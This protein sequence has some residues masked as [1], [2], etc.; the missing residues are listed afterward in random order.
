MEFSNCDMTANIVIQKKIK[1]EKIKCEC[2]EKIVLSD[3][4]KHVEE[5]MFHLKEIEE[6]IKENKVK[7]AKK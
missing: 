4:N 7:D 1:K 3:Y 2:N 5:C 6:S